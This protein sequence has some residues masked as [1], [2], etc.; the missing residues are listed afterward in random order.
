MSNH[1]YMLGDKQ[2]SEKTVFGIIQNIV[3]KS[4]GSSIS[5]ERLVT[6]MGKV[7]EW[8]NKVKDNPSQQVY[9]SPLWCNGYILGAVRRLFIRQ[10]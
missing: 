1:D 2:A 7:K 6:E 4:P 8:S 3:K 10:V 5:H 9:G